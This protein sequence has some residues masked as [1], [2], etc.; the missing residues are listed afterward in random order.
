MVHFIIINLIIFRSKN[1]Q[2]YTE[3]ASYDKLM[4]S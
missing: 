3:Y 2:L 4:L 1:Y